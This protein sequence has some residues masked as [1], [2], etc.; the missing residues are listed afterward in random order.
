MN[1]ITADLLPLAVDIATLNVLRD[2]PRRGDVEAVRK[3]YEQFGQRKPIVVRRGDRVVLAGNHQLLAA[4]EL[5]WESIAVV[6][7][8]DDD[9]TAM[10]FTLADNRTGDLGSYDDALLLLLLSQVEATDNAALFAA[11]GFDTFDMAALLESSTNGL[12][13]TT[14][15]PDDHFDDSE[16]PTPE[17]DKGRALALWGSTVGEPDVTPEN[18]SEWQLGEHILVVCDVHKDWARYIHHLTGDALLWPYPSLL[19]PFV[20]QARGRKLVLVQP[21][22]YLAGWSITKWQ[23]LTGETAV[24]VTA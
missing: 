6:W 8:D 10:A 3:S 2:N 20:V 1:T 13:G 18:G 16:D 14:D 12:S 11:T 9:A 21:N 22:R 23:R 17:T 4:R 5:G 19:A 24:E 15:E 7:V